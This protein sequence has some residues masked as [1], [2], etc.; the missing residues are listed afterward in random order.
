[1]ARSPVACNSVICCT[2]NFYSEYVRRALAQ[3]EFSVAAWLALLVVPALVYDYALF[4][5][6]VTLTVIRRLIASQFTGNTPT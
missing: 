6:R 5:V 2:V 4:F 3:R 1:M